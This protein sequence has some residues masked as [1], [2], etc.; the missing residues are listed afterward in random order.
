MIEFATLGDPEVLDFARRH[1][2]QI[3]RFA[4]FPGRNAALGRRTTP[5]G[6]GCAGEWRGVLSVP[7]RKQGPRRA[8]VHCDVAG[9]DPCLRR[10]RLILTSPSPP[11]K[12]TPSNDTQIWRVHGC[13]LAGEV[14]PAGVSCV[15]AALAPE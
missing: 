14:S 3:A 6:A 15:L 1:H 13:T 2:D 5:A 10:E 12:R 8:S 4:R 7:L 9:L 11:A